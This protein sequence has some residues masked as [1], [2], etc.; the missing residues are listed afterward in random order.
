MM[1]NRQ[2]NWWIIGGIVAVVAVVAGIIFKS[3]PDR[4]DVGVRAPDFTA[5]DLTTGR[6]VS[7]RDTYQGHVTLVNIWATYCIPCRQE[8]PAMDSLYQSL[9]SRGFRIAAV[10]IDPLPAADVKAFADQ[11]HISFDIL[12]DSTGRIEELYR[13]T[14]VPESFLVDQQGRI[15]RI[16]QHAA[17]WN[18]PE[19]RQIVTRLLGPKAG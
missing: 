17:E 19:V 12:Q 18:A 8:I 15:V 11:Y 3:S 1:A 5:T 9:H 6:P 14:G 7:F 2:R 16:V 4:I 10:S 13:T